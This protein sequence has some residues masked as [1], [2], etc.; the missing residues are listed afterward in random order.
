MLAY[1]QHMNCVTRCIYY[2]IGFKQPEKWHFSIKKVFYLCTKRS[3]TKKYTLRTRNT[4]FF[5]YPCDSDE[6]RLKRFEMTRYKPFLKNAALMTLIQS[7]TKLL[8]KK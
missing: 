3:K 7:W 8:E 6:N 2:K 1:F 4:L 5:H